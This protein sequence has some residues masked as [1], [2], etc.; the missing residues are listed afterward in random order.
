MGWGGNFLNAGGLGHDNTKDLHIPT[1][2]KDLP[3]NIKYISAGPY[4]NLALTTDGKAYSW[5]RGDK[6]IS[7]GSCSSQNK[8]LI[9]DAFN[10][11]NIKLINTA[12]IRYCAAIDDKGQ[13][14]TWGDD[15]KCQLGIVK[16][17]L[18]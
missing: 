3:D 16:V 2:I 8:P 1:R 17:Q 6:G 13:L 4:F 10:E 12:N 9:M 7:S 5:G 14:Y 18:I 11:I 15:S